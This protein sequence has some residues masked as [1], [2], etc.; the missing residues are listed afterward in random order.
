MRVSTDW[1]SSPGRRGSKHASSK[2]VSSVR[3]E[4]RGVVTLSTSSSP[5]GPGSSGPS[6]DEALRLLHAVPGV[7]L[8]VR[9]G[10]LRHR[11]VSSV[12]SSVELRAWA[13]ALERLPQP[14]VELAEAARRARSVVSEVVLEHGLAVRVDAI[15][16]T[17]DEVAFHVLDV[18][19]QLRVERQVL[20]A[21]RARLAAQHLAHRASAERLSAL[22]TV[23][24]GVGHEIN[25]PLT[26]MRSNLEF[27]RGE[28][29]RQGA[30]RELLAALDEAD[31]GVSRIASVVRD[32][33]VLTGRSDTGRLE[34]VALLPVIRAAIDAT[35]G[36]FRD[37]APVVLHA[38]GAP[39][40]RAHEANLVL[41]LV[42]LLANAAQALGPAAPSDDRVDVRVLGPLEG[43]VVVEVSDTGRGMDVETLTRAFDPFFTTRPVN[44]GVGLGLAVSRALVEAMGGRLDLESAPGLGTT[45]RLSLPS[46]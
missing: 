37:R 40:V 46:A 4:R 7:A 45:A 8:L 34:V 42:N 10:V 28:L 5:A 9:T 26:W 39:D 1:P 18:T 38:E 22:A 20:A 35:V 36:V 13:F 16:L 21:E 11:F 14:F 27:V 32:L 24:E 17:A 31:E 33:R 30:T 29:E 6:A 43:R 25:N 12:C 19:E 41:V 23:A 3:G 44:V 15:A 2:V